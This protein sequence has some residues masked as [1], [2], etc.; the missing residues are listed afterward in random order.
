MLGEYSA[1]STTELKHFLCFFFFFP[2]HLS[3]ATCPTW[4]LDVCGCGC[5]DLRQLLRLLLILLI[6]RYNTVCSAQL[7]F[8]FCNDF[9][10][11]TMSKVAT[12]VARRKTNGLIKKRQRAETA[13]Q[14]PLAGEFDR[15]ILFSVWPQKS[16]YV[17]A[18][19]LTTEKGY[20]ESLEEVIQVSGQ[21]MFYSG[22]P[23]AVFCSFA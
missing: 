15:E 19:L 10:T 17:V 1:G 21:V 3:H 5:C 22:K 7:S 2:R 8:R 16:A 9:A 11:I 23:G 4:N 6:F 18:E 14:K 12:V 20:I 13:V